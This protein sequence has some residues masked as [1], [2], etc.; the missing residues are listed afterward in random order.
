MVNSWA[1][2]NVPMGVPFYKVVEK[3]RKYTRLTVFFA[4]LMLITGITGCLDPYFLEL[5]ETMK[6]ALALSTIGALLITLLALSAAAAPRWQIERLHLDARATDLTGYPLIGAN[7]F[8]GRVP[9][10]VRSKLIAAAQAVRDAERHY[11]VLFEKIRAGENISEDDLKMAID[12]MRTERDR[13]DDLHRR[14]TVV[15]KLLNDSRGKIF[16]LAAASAA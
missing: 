4:G 2:Q 3:Y 9:Q 12:R 6:G 16:E 5:G 11:N 10:D 8:S 1:E 13:L 15:F 14:A 7:F